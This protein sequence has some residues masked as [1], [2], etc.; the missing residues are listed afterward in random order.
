MSTEPDSQPPL[1]A[2]E[3]ERQKSANDRAED[4]AYTVNHAISCGATDIFVQPIA[5][6]AANAMV[7]EE[8]MPR[9]LR[10]IRHGFEHHHD[11]GKPGHVHKHSD[12][13]LVHLSENGPLVQ[14]GGFFHRTMKESQST[15]VRWKRVGEQIREQLQWKRFV[16]NLAHWGAGETVGDV[17]GI[18]PTIWV[19]RT[20]PGFMSGLRHVLEPV[21][22]VFF[23]NGAARDARQWGRRNG[24]DADSPEVKAKETYFYEHEVSHLPQAV[25]WNSFSI[26]INF[27][28][29]FFTHGNHRESN[30]KRAAL[31]MLPEFIVGK[32]FGTIFSNGILLGGRAAAPDAFIAWDQWNSKHIIKPVLG[33]IGIDKET[34]DKVTSQNHGSHAMPS[35][36]Q[37]SAAARTDWKE[38]VTADPAVEAEPA[39]TATR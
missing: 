13:N 16:G 12:S 15:K 25:V 32:G 17:G 38:R 20:F 9:W 8:L 14:E 21:A 34:I 39:K 33:T 2:K 26:P 10:W 31:H 36:P 5:A 23:R 22:G 24:F 7:T 28:T 1:S 6:T 29:Q 35:V 3:R 27:V 18:V 4:I 19:Q 37:D 11:H 30:W